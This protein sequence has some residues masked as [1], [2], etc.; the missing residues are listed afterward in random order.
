MDDEEEDGEIEQEDGGDSIQEIVEWKCDD[1]E[2][3]CVVRMPVPS[4]EH[5]DAE[6]AISEVL[7]PD[8]WKPK[9]KVRQ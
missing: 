1:C 6:E 4:D 5:E 3:G 7:M 9:K 2:F 8:C